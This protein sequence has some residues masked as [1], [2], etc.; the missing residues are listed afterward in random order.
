MCMSKGVADGIQCRKMQS[1]AYWRHEQDLSVPLEVVEEEKG[2]SHKRLKSFTTVQLVTKRT[3]SWI[4][5]TEQLFM[6][7]KRSCWTCTNHWYAHMLKTVHQC[8]HLVIRKT[9]HWL[10][11]CSIVSQGWFRDSPSCHTV[12][13]LN[14]WDSGVW[15]KDATEPTSLKYL[16]WLKVSLEYQWNLCLNCPPQS[17]SEVMN[18]SWQTQE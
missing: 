16:R 17:T 14:V 15:R 2:A 10:R 4:W 7:L 12:K 9:K 13:D 5:W 6:S 3:E 18:W 8:G 1:Y 11:D